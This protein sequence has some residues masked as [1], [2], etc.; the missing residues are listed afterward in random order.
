VTDPF[1]PTG[2]P[3]LFREALGGYATGVTVVTTMCDIGP[4]GITANSFASVS[5][6]PPL[7]LWSPGKASKRFDAFASAE[8][9]AIHILAD[10]QRALCDQ[11]SRDGLNFDGLDT[12]I[13][14]AGTPLIKG[15]LARLECTQFSTHDGG[16][17][18][19]ILGK[20][21]RVMSRG[22]KPLLFASGGFGS[23]TPNI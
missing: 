16:D 1:D 14:E 13:G 23:F 10:D 2:N 21:N 5:L 7:V 22:G 17:H 9:Y 6:E 19:I 4:L 8:H 20:V 12:D 3:L 18:L 15:C 11:F